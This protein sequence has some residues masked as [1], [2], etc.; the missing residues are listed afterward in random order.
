MRNYLLTGTSALALVFAAGAANAQTA[1]GKFDIK[2]SGDAY[3]EAGFIDHTH[4]T[5]TAGAPGGVDNR[6]VNFTNRFRLVI[7]PVATA[8]NGITYGAVARL[9]ANSGD[10]GAGPYHGTAGLIDADRGYIY[11][12]GTFG[13]VQGGVA[14]GPSD[15]TYVAAP[16][17]WQIYG[18]YDQW[19]AYTAVVTGFT[20][21]AGQSKS[22][23]SA[24][25][26]ATLLGSSTGA[27]DAAGAVVGAGAFT[28]N[29][30]VASSGV[31]L[32]GSH[33]I[34]DK[35]VYYSPRF[36]GQSPT[37]GLQAGFSYEPNSVAVLTGVDRASGSGFSDV[38]EATLNYVENFNGIGVKA[39]AGYGGGTAQKGLVDPAIGGHA[40]DL[41]SA[42]VGLAVSYMNFALGG[43]Y[44]WA[45]DS[46]VAT[47][48][49]YL[50][51]SQDAWNVGGQY[52]WGPV[53]VGIR[54]QDTS[55]TQN[56]GVAG[57]FLAAGDKN[58]HDRDLD[59]LT[60]G[61]LY[62]VAPGLRT[63]LEYTHYEYS[64]HNNFTGK[65]TNGIGGG[66]AP[67]T[68]GHDSGDVFLIR[69]AVTF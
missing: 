21:L 42:Q 43:G 28:G 49:N 56:K 65:T 41:E 32:V 44:V 35:L 57:G 46:G 18:L 62:T 8:D 31:Q 59:A 48:L 22:S 60:A 24:A 30:A 39:S 64:D 55:S 47:V 51:T 26:W 14:A 61:V 13:T 1:P 25:P 45:G 38:Y 12:S 6:S 23:G 67:F 5:S 69:T 34:A 3:F 7:N 20:G 37:T 36:F 54:Y 27:I 29:G 15:N 53:V 50:G 17:D 4:D 9:R 10:L 40:N 52:T 68:A 11:V 58:G 16:G 66:V 2:I 63:G 33:G 19:R